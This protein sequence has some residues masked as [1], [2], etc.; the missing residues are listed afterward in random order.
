MPELVS[1]DYQTTATQLRILGV[2]MPV[3]EHL[4]DTILWILCVI[5]CCW[6][7]VRCK[8]RICVPQ[9]GQKCLQL[10]MAQ[11]QYGMQRN[12][13]YLRLFNRQVLMQNSS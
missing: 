3:I 13:F 1:I 4:I 9:F 5:K 7:W 2:W 6:K 8:N 11:S 10:T 12:Y